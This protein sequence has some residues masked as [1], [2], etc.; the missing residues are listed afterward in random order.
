MDPFVVITTGDYALKIID[1]PLW[2]PERIGEDM[3]DGVMERR[4]TKCAGGK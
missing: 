4:Y 3:W 2:L 1:L